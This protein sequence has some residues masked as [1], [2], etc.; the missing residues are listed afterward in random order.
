MGMQNG[1]ATGNSLTVP[2][3]AKNRFIIQR[4]ITLLATYP[5]EMQT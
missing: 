5:R 4:G 2:F 1:I 3:K